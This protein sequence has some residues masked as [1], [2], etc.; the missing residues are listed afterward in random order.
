[1]GLLAL[2]WLSSSSL[3]NQQEAIWLEDYEA[4]LERAVSQ[5]RPVLMLF[6]GSDWCVWCEKLAKELFESAAFVQFA[7]DRLVLVRL[8]YPRRR[9]L[10]PLIERRNRALKERFSVEAFPTVILVEPSS[11]RIQMR[12][13]YVAIDPLDYVAAVGAALKPR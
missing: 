5:E 10:P 2:L 11:E 13:S 7:Q 3:A 8:D 1:M 4:A 9:R 6:T 12:H